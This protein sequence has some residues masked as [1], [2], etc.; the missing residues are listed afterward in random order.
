MAELLVLII[1][2]S[3][4]VYLVVAGN[5]LW[6]VYL[7]QI[8][9]Y[10]PDRIISHYRYDYTLSRKSRLIILLKLALILGSLLLLMSPEAIVLILSVPMAYVIYLDQ[11]GFVIS[12]VLRGESL[13][14]KVKSIRNILVLAFS[15]L[16]LLSPVTIIT[17]WAYGFLPL[18]AGSAVNLPVGSFADIAPTVE[19]GLVLWKLPVIALVL[20]NIG[21]LSA[22]LLTHPVVIFWV[23]I[24]EPLAVIRRKILMNKARAKLASMAKI[25]IVGITGSY[26]KSTTKEMLFQILKPHFKV[27]RTPKNFNTDIGVSQ[28]ILKDVH[29]GTEVLIAEMGAYKTGEIR[30]AVSVAPPDIAIVTAVGNQ[31]LSIFGSIKKLFAAKYEIVEGIKQDGVAVL[32]GNNEYCIHM[33]EKTNRR[34]ILYFTFSGDKYVISDGVEEGKRHSKFPIDENVY[35]KDIKLSLHGISFQLVYKGKAKQVKT[36][37]ISE[38][39]ISN[40]LAAISA[41]AE[42]GLSLNDIAETINRI[43][44]ELPYLNQKKAK[45]GSTLIDDSYNSNEAGFIS[46]LKFLRLFKKQGKKWVMTRGIIELGNAKK[47]VYERIAKIL[48]KSAQGLIT[49]D[50]E[51]AEAVSAAD[52][53]FEVIIVKSAQGFLNAF[54]NHI[55]PDEIV[56][57]EGRFPP[58]VTSEINA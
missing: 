3:L 10:R 22:D 51:L 9:E 44:F 4:P 14:P 32:N 13:R 2:F 48:V 43:K 11:A 8:K 31:H 38:H 53:K 24:T 18:A 12:N 27:V 23:I 42:L 54:T 46:A 35:A 7:W 45:N 19:N 26:G 39:N 49:S 28:T 58:D 50:L 21:L 55:N 20:L 34:K 47:V 6:F 40:L 15:I 37:I 52:G 25:K 33:A 56:L 41:A 30:S 5:L 16:T 17:Y 29:A 36:N 57:I 1:F